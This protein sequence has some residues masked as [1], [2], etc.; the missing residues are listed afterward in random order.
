[1]NPEIKINS[2]NNEILVEIHTETLLPG[3]ILE[4][5]AFTD[6]H[7]K[8]IGKE[9][10][11]TEEL[12]NQLKSENIEL[13]FYSPPANE[14]QKS[15]KLIEIE[16][17][18]LYPG[19]ALKGDAFTPDGKK[20]VESGEIITADII[21]S[22]EDQGI[23]KFN[24]NKP[25]YSATYYRLDKYIVSN[26]LIEKSL[27]LAKEI[28]NCVLKKTALPKK[29]IENIIEQLIGEISISETY[30]ILNMLKLKDFDSYTYTHSINVAMIS[31][32]F[33]KE[34]LYNSEKL[35]TLGM[36]AILHDLGK[37]LVPK[38]ILN[39]KG[40]LNE[41][42]WEAVQKH[43]IL[44]YEIIK[45]Q[46]NFGPDVESSLLSHHENYDGNGYPMHISRDQIGEICEVITIADTFDALTSETPYHSP[47][48]VSSSF[49]AIQN[50]SGVKFHPRF[51]TEFIN[52]M[53]RRLYGKP[54]I[55]LNSYVM[56]NTKEVA[57]VIHIDPSKTIRPIVVIY[58][59]GKM[60]PLKYPIQVDLQMD[61]SRFIE[62][63]IEDPKLLQALESMKNK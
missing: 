61:K 7:V 6:N 37:I 17:K 62:K 48:P 10:P 55:P 1:M 63:L 23:K 8:K 24:Y 59:N 49:L 52:Y 22:L 18:D 19:I 45:N 5:D 11:I 34:L 56:L 25:V 21:K 47:F 35:K 31:I 40:G 14:V 58:I 38:E 16:T 51:A 39:K 41:N 53:P 50:L 60:E 44:G 33:G 36:G 32:L 4:A 12:I 20:I 30:T 2:D 3:M 57:Q 54:L 9:E 29:D 15:Y 27:Y 46:K 28:E 42:E 26:Q 43:T 13:L